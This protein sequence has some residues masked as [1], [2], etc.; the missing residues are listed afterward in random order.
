[1]NAAYTLLIIALSLASVAVHSN[2]A[3]V[4][5]STCPDDWVLFGDSCYNFRKEKVQW[6]KAVSLCK[7][8]KGY[9]VEINSAAENSWLASQV[10]ERGL[11][12]T[13]IGATDIVK[14]GTFRWVTSNELVGNVPY[15]H[16]GQP[17]NI[18]NG[19]HCLEIDGGS[20]VYKWADD[21]CYLTK[22]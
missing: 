5:A 11:V 22:N 2:G 10:K 18:D 8:L 4:T 16:E 15:F 6:D 19:E 9:L 17:N 7:E 13:W 21:E 20:G 14:E 3:S 1:M 12:L